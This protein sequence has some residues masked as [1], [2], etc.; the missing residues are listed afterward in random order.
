[1]ALSNAEKQRRYRERHLG[2]DGGK[3]RLQAFISVNCDTR[4][5]LLSAHHGC[6]TADVLEALTAGAEKAL[7]GKLPA[8]EQQAYFHGCDDWKP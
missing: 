8:S 1:M 4:L 7:L 6:S 5:K 3:V 2:V